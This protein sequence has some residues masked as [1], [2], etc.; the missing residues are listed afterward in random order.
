MT[1]SLCVAGAALMLTI[2]AHVVVEV[3]LARLRRSGRYPRRGEATMADVERLLRSGSRVWALR[4]YREVHGCSLR[5]A[6]EA[7][8]ALL[9]KQ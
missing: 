5:Q 1:F 9:V 6:R 4:C 7:I 3:R 2:V 8:D